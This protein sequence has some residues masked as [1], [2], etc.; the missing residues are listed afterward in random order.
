[1]RWLGVLAP[2]VA[3]LLV[4]IVPVWAVVVALTL[5]ASA[6]VG[7]G[8]PLPLRG[9]AERTGTATPPE[10]RL[11]LARPSRRR[12]R[13]A[14]RSAFVERPGRRCRPPRRAPTVRREA[15]GRRPRH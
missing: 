5:L 15:A 13:S 14:R 2:T 3:P 11:R 1:M 10:E 4:G 9:A 8:R 7:A 12:L 6:A